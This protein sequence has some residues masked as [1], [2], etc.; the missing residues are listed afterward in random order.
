MQTIRQLSL[1]LAMLGC[2]VGAA[3]GTNRD[4]LKTAQKKILI[5]LTSHGELGDTGRKT[6]FYLSEVTHPYEVF[7]KAG[8]TV[9]FVSPKGGAA[10][11][12][13]V[14]RKD[15]LNAA[16]LDNTAL[17][18]RTQNTLRPDQ[19]DA[20]DYAAIFFAGGHGTMWDFAENVA[21]QALATTI[22]EQ[23]GV[24]SA[25]CHGPAGL[26]NIKLSSGEYLVKGKQ[27]AAFTN[28]EEAAVELQEVVPFHLETRLRERGALPQIAP[29]FKANV[30]T[31]ERLV[32]GQNPASAAGVAEGV[33]KLLK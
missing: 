18:A 31:S 9:D 30:V 15:P 28:A 21:L 19:V 24:V 11:M 13:G 12:D 23:N 7:T 2:L 27:V 1:T 22:Y 17:L 29:N 10:P 20:K 26:V 32:T 16:F 3:H 8:Y 14:D 4:T 25:V 33:L 5:A 6:G